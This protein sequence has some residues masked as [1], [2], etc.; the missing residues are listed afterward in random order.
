MPQFTN[1]QAIVTDI[2]GTTSSISFVHDVLFP[3]A[4]EKLPEFVREHFARPDIAAV[5]AEVANESALPASDREGL[6]A[7]LLQ[8]IRDDKKVTPLKTLQGLI[9]E[10]GYRSGDYRAHVYPDVA[11]QLQ[12]W[13]NVGLGLYVYSSGSVLAQKL[14]F[15]FSDAGNLLP[16]FEGHFDTTTGGKRESE[17]YRRI[18]EEIGAAAGQ[19]LFL[20]DVVAELAA[21]RE[22]GF[23]TCLLLRPGNA[24]AGEHDFPVS[25]S[26]ADI[27][28]LP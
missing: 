22:A 18:S 4:A 13:K 10:A 21:A 14:F 9:W 7:Q 16:L 2:E 12:T 26:F 23:Q 5:L 3:Y 27:R 19:L 17:S 1:V 11:P 25:R 15:E 8:W 20:S 28:C 6:I 24:A